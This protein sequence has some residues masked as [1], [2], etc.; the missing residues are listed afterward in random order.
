MPKDGTAIV[1]IESRRSY[2]L[3]SD[4]LDI[5]VT[6]PLLA[7]GGFERMFNLAIQPWERRLI[8]IRLSRAVPEIEGKRAEFHLPV[9]AYQGPSWFGPSKYEFGG[10]RKFTSGSKQVMCREVMVEDCQVN[11]SNI[12]NAT[13]K[14]NNFST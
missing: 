5:M 8:K 3:T 14:H 11:H 6:F 9:T 7:V 1:E 2:Q 13:L 10:W 4:L 12:V